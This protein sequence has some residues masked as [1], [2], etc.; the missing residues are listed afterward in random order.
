V[1]PAERTL[2]VIVLALVLLLSPAIIVRAALPSSSGFVF[3]LLRELRIWTTEI[4]GDDQ[5]EPKEAPLK[6]TPHQ[7]PRQRAAAREEMVFGEN[8]Y[9]H[10]LPQTATSE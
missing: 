8:A 9:I 1:E 4:I 5:N 3:K 10:Q 6:K 2:L 7:V